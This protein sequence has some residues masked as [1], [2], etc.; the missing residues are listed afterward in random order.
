MALHEPLEKLGDVIFL[1]IKH[2]AEHVDLSPLHLFFDF[3]Q[4]PFLRALRFNDQN[5]AVNLGG[6]KKRFRVAVQRRGIQDNVVKPL[7]EIFQ[8]IRYRITI[9]Q[10]SRRGIRPSNRQQKKVREIGLVNRRVNL[11]VGGDD[12]RQ[13][14]RR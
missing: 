11:R 2:H 14:R 6:Q 10:I 12:I 3:P 9:E 7:P 4:S 1:F 8:Q 13:S 5:H